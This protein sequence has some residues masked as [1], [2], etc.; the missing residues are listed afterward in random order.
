MACIYRI[1][2]ENNE[3]GNGSLFKLLS[4]DKCASCQVLRGQKAKDNNCYNLDLT[5]ET[6]PISPIT[7]VKNPPVINL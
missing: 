4:S 7:E 3:F 2:S 5:E 6:C 1:E